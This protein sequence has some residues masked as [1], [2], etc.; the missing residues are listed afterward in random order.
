V[1]ARKALLS[2]SA[3][4]ALTLASC[5]TLNRAGKDLFLG[6]GTPVLILYGGSVDGWESAK[7]AREGMDSGGAFEVLAFPFTFLYHGFEH[8][9]Y[10]VAHIIDLPLCLFYGLA[11]IG[12]V[13]PEVKP[14][15]IY[16]GTVFD[17]WA[18][19]GHVD[20]HL[21]NADDEIASAAG[22]MCGV[23]A[24]DKSLGRD[25]PGVHARSA[26]EFAFDHRD[27][28]TSVGK[29]PCQWWAGLA[30]PDDDRVEML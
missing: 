7:A 10:G 26:D 3:I 9:I 19:S 12:G 20:G 27:G 28:L 5:G 21:R 30:G 18:G 23:R 15:D 24:G 29:P 17:K 11:E 1:N 14:L 2:V 4:L 13:M 6:V 16:T 8:T 25:A 22:E